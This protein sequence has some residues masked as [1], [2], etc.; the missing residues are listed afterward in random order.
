MNE[1]QPGTFVMMMKN[2]D[3]SFS[4]IGTTKEQAHIILSFLSR[5]SEDEP[6]I[7]KDNEKYVQATRLS[8]KGQ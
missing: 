4:P 8:T 6:F 7:V 1:L 5:L 3:G 2:E